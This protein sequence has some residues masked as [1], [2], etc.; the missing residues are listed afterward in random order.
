MPDENGGLYQQPHI[1]ISH[2]KES[3]QYVYPNK[4][5][6]D[7]ERRPDYH[8]HAETLIEQLGA[9]LGALPAPGADDRIAIDGLKRGVLVEVE[10]MLPTPQAKATKIPA[11]DFPLQEIAVLRSERED[12]RTERAVVFVPDDARQFLSNR[13]ESYGREDLGNQ[14]RPDVEKF[15]VLEHIRT[16][17]ASSLVV[18]QADIQSDDPI[19]W[20]LWL[21][22]PDAVVVAVEAAM[23]AANLEVHPD[24]LTFPDTVILFAHAA[25]TQLLPLVGRLN[26][27]ISEIRAANRNIETFLEHGENGL[28]QH[29]WV[30]DYV[31][32]VT[33]PPADAPVICV[34]DTGIAAAHPLVAPALAGAWTVNA[35]WGA[36]DHA[37]G[38]GHGTGM[39][40]LVLHGDLVG[41]LADQRV[42][43]LGHQVESVKF[44]PPA[45]FPATE[46]ARYG[47]VTQAA[48]SVA[49]I[50]RAG[51]ARSFCLA[52][53]TQETGSDAPS[54]W[55]GA[56]D[57][58]CAGSMSGERQVDVAAK[59]HPKRLMLVATG[60]VSGGQKA[61]VTRH[62]SLED[63]AQSWNA[64]SI[65]GYTTKIDLSPTEP[66]LTPL[67][68]ANEKS[69]FSRG[70]QVLPPDLTPIKPEVMFEAGN[71]MVD[72]TDYCGINPVVSLITTGSDLI[73]EPLVPFCATS[74]ATGVAGNFVGQLQ[75]ALPN[76]WPETYRALT[77]HSAE[78]PQPIRSKFIGKGRSWRSIS[79]GAKQA[80]LRDVGF[81]VPDLERAIASASNDVTLLAEA[82]IQPFV[83]TLDNRAVFN[84]AHF[85][86]LPWPRD[87]LEALE[88]FPVIMKVTLSYFIEPNLSGRAGTRPDTY[89]SFGLRFA[90]KKRRETTHQFRQRLSRTDEKVEKAGGETDYWLVGTQAVQAG[91]LHCDLWRGPAIDLAAHDEIAIF[92]VGGWWKSHTG[93]G[94]INDKA[95]YSL[96]ISISAR[97]QDVNLYSEIMT[98]IETRIAA[99]VAIVATQGQQG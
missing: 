84:E 94:R 91:S 34:I 27:A 10:T 22:R 81:G 38:G 56:L 14:K 13:I 96:A 44:L 75:S 12:D 62:H 82:E 21:R 98:E 66:G 70:S 43:A 18:G 28:G 88:N 60:N 87:A 8:A 1:K 19:W 33:P 95:R 76:L 83:R 97:D 47:F 80:I 92:P 73:I 67:V 25:A 65:G 68:G 50:E 24:R 42:V 17:T 64:L 52:T 32:R 85:Y 2:W 55:S 74:A 41:P 54:S 69:P 29:A 51:A 86:K 46:P 59:D 6:K 39:A 90:L 7:R 3:A 11:L 4:P 57:Q 79:K 26:G 30:E 37:A 9:A 53:S 48:V 5:R 15:E 99:E 77:V 63:P 71:M 20:E 61:D 49:E 72:A 31:A 16:A 36:D 35:A 45:G 23:G 93:Q 89:R 78:W 40:G 58:I